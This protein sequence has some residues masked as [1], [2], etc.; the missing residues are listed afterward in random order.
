MR[1]RRTLS[2]LQCVQAPGLQDGTGAETNKSHGRGQPKI[3]KANGASGEYM[4]VAVRGVKIRPTESVVPGMD[5][6]IAP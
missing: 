6:W 4:A 5:R 3:R 2:F 1:S